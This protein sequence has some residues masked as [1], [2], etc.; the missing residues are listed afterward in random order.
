MVYRVGQKGP[1]AIDTGSRLGMSILFLENC[2]VGLEVLV[3]LAKEVNHYFRSLSG[4]SSKM[5][6]TVT[7]RS[8][9]TLKAGI[10]PSHWA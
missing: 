10:E 3:V 6:E 2:L 1:Q 7:R 4:I 8:I 9:T 5:R